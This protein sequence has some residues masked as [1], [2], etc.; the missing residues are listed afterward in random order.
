MFIPGNM[1][2][3][4]QDYLWALQRQCL[5]AKVAFKIMS[6]ITNTSKFG[7]IKYIKILTQ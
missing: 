7:D 1:F 4:Y 6:S 3:S 5:R 2:Q